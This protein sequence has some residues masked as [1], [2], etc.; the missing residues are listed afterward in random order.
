[1]KALLVTF[2]AHV[3][4]GNAGIIEGFLQPV[5]NF[6]QLLAVVM[7]GLLSAQIGK[8]AIWTIPLTFAVMMTLGGLVGFAI[9]PVPPIIAYG[10][11]LSLIV[12]GIVLVI[13]QE[14][15]EAII[16]III[17][18][19][20]IFHGYAH[21]EAFPPEQTIVFFIAYIGGIIISTAGLAVISV[22]L[23]FITLR[24]D[25]GALILRVIGILIVLIGLYFLLN[26]SATVSL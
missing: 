22:M 26:V 4:P 5:I 7:I 18:I 17:G 11:A 2:L 21:G 19:F 10:T 23:G 8:R 15:P 24:F 3:L 16:L 12:F 6:E 25:R 20:A 9:G 1:M 14:I 13:Q